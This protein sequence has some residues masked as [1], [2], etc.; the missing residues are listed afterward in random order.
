V[1]AAGGELWISS[2]VNG[3]TIIRADGFGGTRGEGRTMR[4]WLVAVAASAALMFSLQTGSLAATTRTA[5]ALWG[6]P[7]LADGFKA[8]PYADPDAP[9][10]GLLSLQITATSG[11]QNF[12][13]FDTLNI[14]S[15]RG[16]GAAGMSAMRTVV[17]IMVGVQVLTLATVLGYRVPRGAR[18][19]RTDAESSS[20]AA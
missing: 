14:F 5:L 3:P 7:K 16:N 13:T 9:K 20:S 6:E 8:F 1:H 12:D 4:R 15:R 19:D 2:P 17:A 18:Q 10:G 11:N